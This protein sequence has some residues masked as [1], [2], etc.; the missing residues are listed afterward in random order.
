MAPRSKVARGSKVVRGKKQSPSAFWFGQR[1]VP[2]VPKI[3]LSPDSEQHLCMSSDD[4]DDDDKDGD[5]DTNTQ[6]SRRYASRDDEVDGDDDDD[7]DDD[8]E[9]DDDDDSQLDIDNHSHDTFTSSTSSGDSSSSDPSTFGGNILH[10]AIPTSNPVPPIFNRNAFGSSDP[11]QQRISSSDSSSLIGLRRNPERN[12]RPKGNSYEIGDD[13]SEDGN[14]CNTSSSDE[15]ANVNAGDSSYPMSNSWKPSP[16]SS[17]DV[18]T[19]PLSKGR[20]MTTGPVVNLHLGSPVRGDVLRRKSTAKRIGT[21]SS[22]TAV[23]ALRLLQPGKGGNE[24]EGNDSSRAGKHKKA[25]RRDTVT[26]TIATKSVV[27]PPEIMECLNKSERK[28]IK[29]LLGKTKAALYYAW[30]EDYNDNP[31]KA[32]QLDPPRMLDSERVKR[33]DLKKMYLV[34]CNCE[35]SLYSLTDSPVRLHGGLWYFQLP[36]IYMLAKSLDVLDR[37]V[38]VGANDSFEDDVVIALNGQRLLSL[39]SF[40][41]I[42]FEGVRDRTDGGKTDGRRNN[43]QLSYGYSKQGF[44]QETN[45]DGL[46]PP[47]LLNN[48][49]NK[50]LIGKQYLALSNLIAE[51]DPDEKQYDR[52]SS[53]FRARN[54]YAYQAFEATG[55]AASEGSLNVIENFSEIRN[56]LDL[57]RL[58]EMKHEP[59]C[60][61]HFDEGNSGMDGY[62]SFFSVNKTE[63]D[64]ETATVVRLALTGYNKGSIDNLM[65][66]KAVADRIHTLVGDVVPS[67]SVVSRVSGVLA[68]QSRRYDIGGKPR[69]DL[70]VVDA[71]PN[72]SVFDSLP[73]YSFLSVLGS[74]GNSLPLV[75]E[76]ASAI[77]LTNGNDKVYHAFRHLEELSTLPKENLTMYFAKWC[78][79]EFGDVFSKG[80]FQRFR[81][82]TQKPYGLPVAISN[83]LVVRDVI[84][85]ANNDGQSFSESME[86]LKKYAHGVSDVQGPRIL[87]LLSI[88]GCIVPNEYAVGAEMSLKLAKQVCTCVDYTCFCHKFCSVAH[89][90][91][92]SVCRSS[93]GCFH[94]TTSP[95]APSLPH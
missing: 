9:D 34:A 87:R 37:I 93:K 75:A 95:P 60:F 41:E 24:D 80:S 3:T 73:A 42:D 45:E 86:V 10:R 38:V 8:D 77:F 22:T 51:F 89:Y 48:S 69:S 1:H 90:F 35:G 31:K 67:S 36:Q 61:P 82:P 72:I 62:S 4:G 79:A 92:S 74:H 83:S 59:P 88:V 71:D 44:Q 64:K 70:F 21:R 18:S 20:A 11:L 46:H 32:G 12:A 6:T 49:K 53:L 68:E 94:M 57:T 13:S 50:P 40:H 30:G 85:S 81:P 27:I 29:S 76:L 2:A 56:N 78:N 23:K 52:S 19:V 54:K 65:M 25:P 58:E 28:Q 7:V 91:L 26:N 17:F 47:S 66:Q 39:T 15:S 43:I 5:D 55:H 16:R 63:Y 14:D 84:L 33:C